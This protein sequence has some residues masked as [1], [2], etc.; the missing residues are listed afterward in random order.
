MVNGQSIV[1]DGVWTKT[2]YLSPRAL[3][4]QWIAAEDR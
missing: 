2:K 3:E 1:V 4:S